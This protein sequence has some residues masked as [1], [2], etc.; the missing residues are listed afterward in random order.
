MSDKILCS[1]SEA[2]SL[3]KSA[4]SMTKLWTSVRVT[5]VFYS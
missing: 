3:V 2:L 1:V 5:L 4:F